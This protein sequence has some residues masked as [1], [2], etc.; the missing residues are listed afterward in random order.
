M[1]Q[2]NHRQNRY[3][4]K[5]GQRSHRC[6]RN[7]AA[8]AAKRSVENSSRRSGDGRS[9]GPRHGEEKQFKQ[10]TGGLP[11]KISQEFTPHLAQEYGDDM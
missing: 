5:D 10:P 1:I 11:Q 4:D 6:G 8:K 9:E 7:S 3:C 2:G